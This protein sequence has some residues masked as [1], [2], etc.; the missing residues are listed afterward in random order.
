MQYVPA[1]DGLGRV[2]EPRQRAANELVPPAEHQHDPQPA[3][4]VDRHAAGEVHEQ[5]GVLRNPA[6][7]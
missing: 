3:V 1:E 6:V 4:Q 5:A 2:P 7:P